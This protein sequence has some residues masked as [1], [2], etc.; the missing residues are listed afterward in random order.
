VGCTS[1]ALTASPPLLLLR[2]RRARQTQ[3]QGTPAHGPLQSPA[4]HTGEQRQQP[5]C[6]RLNVLLCEHAPV[7]RAPELC[8]AASG[9]AAR[10]VGRLRGG[11]VQLESVRAGQHR[12]RLLHGTRM[13]SIG[14]E[15]QHERTNSNGSK[16]SVISALSVAS[17]RIG[18]AATGSSS[19]VVMRSTSISRESYRAVSPVYPGPASARCLN[20]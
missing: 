17:R 14:S 3:Q 7:C 18:G 9:A 5:C 15:W 1:P 8:C 12:R 16:P 2:R 19:D 4:V 13:L 11:Q 10:A 6:R 20:E